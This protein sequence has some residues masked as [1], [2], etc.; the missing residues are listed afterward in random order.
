MIELGLIRFRVDYA[1]EYKIIEEGRPAVFGLLGTEANQ[2]LYMQIEKQTIILNSGM[3]FRTGGSKHFVPNVYEWLY[4]AAMN[5]STHMNMSISDFVYLCWCIG[6]QNTLPEDMVP[7]IVGRRTLEVCDTF[8][9]ELQEYSERIDSILKK[10]R[11]TS[12]Y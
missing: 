6:V 8:R 3:G 2:N 7:R 10:M 5:T 1:D 9:L 12:P 11:N 4:D